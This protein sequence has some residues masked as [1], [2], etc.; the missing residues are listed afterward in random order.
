[1][2]NGFR[3]CGDCSPFSRTADS[4]HAFTA[5]LARK[6]L[7]PVPDLDRNV[8]RGPEVGAR[9]PIF[10]A[11]DQAGRLQTFEPLCG[12]KGLVLMFYRSADW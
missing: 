10:E 8:R 3:N 9:F 1:M 6:R 11:V 2:R 4:S 5:K 7:R 12:P